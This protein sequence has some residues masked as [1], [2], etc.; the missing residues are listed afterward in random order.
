MKEIKKQDKKKKKENWKKKKKEKRKVKASVSSNIVRG[1]S[2]LM[3]LRVNPFGPL[4]CRPCC[5]KSGSLIMIYI[6][7]QCLSSSLLSA[8]LYI[9]LYIYKFLELRMPTTVDCVLSVY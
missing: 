5:L 6:T 1:P 8:N 7:P 9:P 4:A 3:R 2:Q